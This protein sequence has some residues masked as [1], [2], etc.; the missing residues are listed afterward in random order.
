M[1]PITKDLQHMLAYICE[2]EDAISENDH[3]INFIISSDRIDRHNEI[4]EVGAVEKA[5]PAFSKN[6]CCLACH[7]HRLSDGT[8]P[9]I[10][11]WDTETFR[12]FKH[13]SE[14]RLRFAVDTKLGEN[15]W[16]L[17]SA[18]HMRAVSIGFIPLEWHEEKDEKKG[19]H[20]IHTLIELIEISC[21][22]VGA[23]REA[24]ARL[25]E[26]YSRAEVQPSALDLQKAITEAV[27]FALDEKINTLMSE[28]TERLDSFKSVIMD[29]QDRLR[30]RQL[31]N[32]LDS[33]GFA[34]EQEKSGPTS[35]DRI[36]AAF[37]FSGEL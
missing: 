35:L 31:G 25:K 18:R 26:Y 12:A 27:E 30:G 29:D 14:M 6:P 13:H 8:A 19:R 37:N 33:D 4:V 1:E 32:G 7:Q 20:W 5:I 36:K 10:G 11:S 15:Y 3:S 17:Y 24:L 21:V 22:A 34:S 2:K 23:S 9:V 28:L 16:L